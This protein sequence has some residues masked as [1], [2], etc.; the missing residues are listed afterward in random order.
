MRLGWVL[1]LTVAACAPY[2]F[3]RQA[4][5][6]AADVDKV[7][8]GVAATDDALAT[9]RATA[10]QL[11]L[12]D[13]RARVEKSPAC[14]VPVSKG[15]KGSDAPCLI[16][17][18]NGAPSAPSQVEQQLARSMDAMAAWRDSARALAAGTNA[19][20]RA[21]Y[22]AAVGKLA[23][24]VG[25]LAGA[26]GPAGAAAGTAVTAGAHTVG[27]LIGEAL[28]EQRF[29]SLT[30]AVNAVGTAPPGS[31]TTI[32]IVTD[33]IGKGLLVA[34]AE[35]LDT[36]NTELDEDI[37][38]LGPALPDTAYRQRLADAE[39]LAATIQSLRAADPAAAANALNAAHAALVKAVND[40]SRD[41]AGLDKA[42]AQF[43]A[44]AQA[45]RT[46]LT[47]GA[48]PHAAA[49]KP[50]AAAAKKGS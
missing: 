48:A 8:D 20:D 14:E 13:A 47:A 24:A 27:W 10:V 33:A 40:P 46:D 41:A 1:L 39:A 7:S 21:A 32:R 23:D 49:P 6:F 36:L 17:A 30:A 37:A 34:R 31:E 11:H 45:L 18:R 9:D 2:D 26:A 12:D 16:F 42:L 15:V 50:K 29:D 43:A 35:R 19:A 44:Q 28:D 3:S 5:G 25:G 38:G 4:A 22:D